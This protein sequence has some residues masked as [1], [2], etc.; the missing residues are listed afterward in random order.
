[1]TQFIELSKLRADSIVPIT[2]RYA[3][4]S[5]IYYGEKRILTFDTYNKRKY[6]FDGNEKVM[7]I[8]KGIE[9]RPDLVSYDVYGFVSNWWRILEVNNMKDIWEFKSG[10]TII[11]PNRVV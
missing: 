7:L 4:Q 6:N 9:Y 3:N 10:K 11:I 5:V 8:T 1:M 2:S